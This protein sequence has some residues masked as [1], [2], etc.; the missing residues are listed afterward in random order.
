MIAGLR[1]LIPL[2]QTLCSPTMPLSQ[3]GRLPQVSFLS[4]SVR[5]M[6]EGV[7]HPTGAGVNQS[8]LMNYLPRLIYFSFKQPQA[9]RPRWDVRFSGSTVLLCLLAAMPSTATSTVYRS[10]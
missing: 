4:C 1:T 9:M 3:A 2:I 7:K 5:G 6:P 8:L 10:I